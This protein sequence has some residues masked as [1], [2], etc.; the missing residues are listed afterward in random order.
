MATLTA[1]PAFQTFRDPAGSVEIRPDAV[2][3]TVQP[4]FEDD[5]LAFLGSPLAASLVASGKLIG[6]EVLVPTSGQQSLILRHPRIA[7]PSYPWEWSPAMW[8][9]AAHLTLDLCRELLNE[10]WILKDATPLNILFRGAQPVFI[11]VLSIERADPTQPLWIAYAQFIRTFILPMLAHSRLGWPLHATL[12]RRD[13]YQPEDLFAALSPLGRLTRPAFSCVTLPHLLSGK[14]T[15]RAATPPPALQD[16]EVAR[17]V[18]LRA[19]ATLESHIRRVTPQR[20]SQS[21]WTEYA[22]TAHHYSEHDH[23]D[24]RAFV[25]TAL[26]DAHPIHVLDI[27]CNA[28]VYSRLAAATGAQVVS[29]DSDLQTVDRLAASLAGSDRNILPL[30][31]DL[32]RP[33]P[34]AGWEYRES[35]SFLD[36]ATGHFDTV[37]ML[38]V[39]HHLLLSAQIP[40]DRIAA[41]C[42][43]LAKRNLILEW[44]P[45]TDPMFVEILRGRESIYAHIT[46]AAFRAAFAPYFSVRRETT[47][48]NGR[49]LL[50]LAA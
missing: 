21:V 30:C 24:K 22:G 45:P 17:H 27:G 39:L 6:S 47:L 43:A 36:R 9:A 42:A 29:I 10:G 31:V 35:L 40:L 34:A 46:E 25:A 1:Q 20:A 37:M 14:S 23:A 8:A 13:G 15:R 33:T 48:A 19:L 49:I 12:A 41:L 3:R 26:A 11:D 28:G 18:L 32:A 44:V 38:A 16:P 5:I 2:Y 4:A 50:H 7:F